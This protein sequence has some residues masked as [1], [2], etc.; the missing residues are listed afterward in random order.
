MRNNCFTI[1]LTPDWRSAP[2]K[3]ITELTSFTKS[4][5]FQLGALEKNVNL[6]RI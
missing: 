1:R 2:T 6:F 4:A 3:K 5:I